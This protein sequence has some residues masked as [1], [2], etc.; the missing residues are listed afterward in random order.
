MLGAIFLQQ[1]QQ[2]MWNTLPALGF[3]WV[4]LY[5]FTLGSGRF[6]LDY[7]ITKKRANEK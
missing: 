4:S 2:G 5:S 1:I 6:G 7:L 3:L